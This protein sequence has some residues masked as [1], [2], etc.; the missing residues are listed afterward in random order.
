MK[1]DYE[2]MLGD[3]G[4]SKALDIILK[5]FKDEYIKAKQPI[6]FNRKT[7]EDS[8]RIHVDSIRKE[9]AQLGNNISNIKKPIGS[10]YIDLKFNL[11]P[12][13]NLA[14]GEEVVSQ[15]VD[16]DTYLSSS[17]TNTI[18]LGEPGAG[19]TSTILHIANKLVNTPREEFASRFRF[20]IL[21]RFRELSTYG[22]KSFSKE[23]LIFDRIFKIFGL[24]DLD[25]I[26]KSRNIVENIAIRALN[27]LKVLLVLDGFDEYPFADKRDILDEIKVLGRS[28]STSNFIL[29][30]RSANF[31][32]NITNSKRFEIARLD[33]DQ[34]INL[35]KIWLDSD[36]EGENFYN[37]LLSKTYL[38]TARRPLI[39]S[40]LLKIYQAP[41]R[42]NIPGKPSL[43]AKPKD[44]YEKVVEILI[45]DWDE[46]RGLD[47]ET[48]FSGFK[49]PKK[50]RF[51][52]TLSYTLTKKFYAFSFNENSIR[53][54]YLDLAEA[55]DL[56]PEESYE[57][58]KEL[59]SH[60]GLFLKT[61]E[62]RYEFAHKVVQ[63][64]FTAE[65]LKGIAV[66]TKEDIDFFRIPSELAILVGIS[67]EPNGHF[68]AIVELLLDSEPNL[69]FVNIWLSRIIT[70]QPNFTAHEDLAYYSLLLYEL[71]TK[72]EESEENDLLRIKKTFQEF[73]EQPAI[74][75]SVSK[76]NKYYKVNP[77]TLKLLIQNR[78]YYQ[79]GM[80]IEIMP[81]DTYVKGVARTRRYESKIQTNIDF[82]AQWRYMEN[83]I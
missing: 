66:F 20:I 61:G 32:Y 28:L 42:R 79:K 8:L 73:I 78:D 27:E 58:M 10:S 18:I 37:Q 34:I 75:K 50:K 31:P 38:E 74:N 15:K 52:Y 16:L 35:S 77:E 1:N 33:N 39:L 44:I 62:N 53:S 24:N 57:V 14:Q 9:S 60:S 59:E 46:E 55:F 17:E 19:K 63:E 43:P 3:Y 83:L 7:V 69:D 12:K 71:I 56:P 2:K 25:D 23:E 26:S 30:S 29:T 22:S 11:N 51:L 45:R 47:R 81:F 4:T 48:E 64:Y 72:D 54:I 5:F 13:N 49:Y 68:I 67:N 70:E 40:Y 6:K 65:Y 36:I 82:L 21:I 76:L 80:M 41:L